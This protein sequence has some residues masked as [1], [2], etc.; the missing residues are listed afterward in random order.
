MLSVTTTE[1]VSKHSQLLRCNSCT[2]LHKGKRPE[3]L[4]FISPHFG[5]LGMSESC[6]W[7]EFTKPSRP[8]ISHLWSMNNSYTSFLCPQ[9]P[10]AQL[11]LAFILRQTSSRLQIF[12]NIFFVPCYMRRLVFSV[13]ISTQATFLL[14][15]LQSL[16]TLQ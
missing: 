6:L 1:G 16:N 9:T 11:W 13:F 7:I 12:N 10:L 4:V 8:H 5:N 2:L 14:L 15:I 3:I